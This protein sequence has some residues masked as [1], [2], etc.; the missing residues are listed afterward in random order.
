ML[1]NSDLPSYRPNCLYFRGDIPCRPHKLYG[2]HCENCEYFTPQCGIILIIKLGAAGDIIRTTP[3]LRRIETEYPGS[4]VWW[5][6]YTP[7][8]LPDTVKAFTPTAANFAILSAMNFAAVINLD[9]DLEAC[10]VAKQLN[11]TKFIGFTLLNGKPAPCDVRAKPK[12]IRGIFDDIS[13][14]NT[15]SYPQEIFSICGWNF[16]GEEYV[17]PTIQQEPVP[18]LNTS[19]HGLI[20]GLN[21]GCGERWTSRLWPDERWEELILRIK[22][23]GMTALLLGGEQE[24]ARNRKLQAQTGAIMAEPASLRRFFGIMNNCHIVVTAV[25]MGLHIAIGL[26]KRVVLMNNIFNPNEFELYGRGEIA[27]PSQECKCY[28]LP[29]CQ[30]SEYW[31]MNHLSVDTVFAAVERQATAL[32]V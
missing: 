18:G 31:C 16:A 24:A 14:Q 28:Y 17:L 22:D 12:F 23:A 10:A 6:T 30:N 8:V 3:L 29:T 2:V 13:K 26:Q 15:E 25:T 1:I 5:L 7:D 32:S 4:P 21:T 9:K 19:A 20:V 27:R 11:A